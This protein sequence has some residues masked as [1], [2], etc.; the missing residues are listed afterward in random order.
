MEVIKK[1]LYPNKNDILDPLSLVIKLYIYSFKPIGTKISILNNRIEFQEAGIFQS[2]VRTFNGDTKNDLINMLF[3]LTYA[4]EKY[5][6]H[7]NSNNIRYDKIFKQVICSLDKLNQ[8]YQSNEI[9]HNIEQLKNIINKF[10]NE[11]KFNPETII[12]NYNEPASMLK[13]NF[14][15]QTNSVWTDN[16]LV[17]LLEYIEEINNSISEENTQALIVSLNSFMNWID[18]LVVKLISDLH[19]LR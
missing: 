19:L 2:T 15:T 12:S 16:R 6:D 13:K 1:I 4:C 10:I 5:I 8:I 7:N 11:K 3:P 18:L 9:T 17:I 14:Y